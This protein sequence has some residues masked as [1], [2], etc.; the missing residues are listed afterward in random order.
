[1]DYQ[2]GTNIINLNG[3]CSLVILARPRGDLSRARTRHDEKP[4]GACGAHASAARMKP[5]TK[6]RFFAQASPPAGLQSRYFAA[7]SSA[8]EPPSADAPSSVLPELPAAAGGSSADCLPACP[9][10]GLPLRHRTGRYGPFIGCSGFPSCRHTGRY[11][12]GEPPPAAGP[13]AA[14]KPRSSRSK[15]ARWPLPR[16]VSDLLSSL[17]PR[18]GLC[19]EPLAAGWSTLREPRIAI[20]KTWS[21]ACCACL[22]S[23]NHV[24]TEACVTVHQGLSF[25]GDIHYEW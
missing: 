12:A 24:N 15:K 17:G 8:P 6:S 2:P 21:S 3:T 18:R 9:K 11:G 7:R 10:C 13:S 19:G 14:T 25:V 1:M 23:L 20:R 4:L 16:C 5:A 22:N